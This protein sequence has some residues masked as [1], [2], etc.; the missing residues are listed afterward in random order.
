MPRF[1]PA[2]SSHADLAE[3][4]AERVWRETLSA[5]SAQAVR[6]AVAAAAAGSGTV[7]A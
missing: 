7:P 1:G 2:T 4:L 5:R 3:A 6:G